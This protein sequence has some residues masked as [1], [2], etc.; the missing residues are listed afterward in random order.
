MLTITTLGIAARHK[1]APAATDEEEEQNL[2]EQ[3][4]SLQGTLCISPPLV[5][6]HL[7]AEPL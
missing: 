7:Q 4:C 1:T 2:R 6:A 3:L 5:K